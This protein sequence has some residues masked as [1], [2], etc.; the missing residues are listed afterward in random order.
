MGDSFKHGWVSKNTFMSLL[1]FYKA[2]NNIKTL[3]ICCM[4]TL[5]ERLLVH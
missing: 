3:T 2:I 1:C 5:K 4:D